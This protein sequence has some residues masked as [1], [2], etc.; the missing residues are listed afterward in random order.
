MKKP[1]QHN[2]HFIRVVSILVAT[3][4]CMIA[5]VMIGLFA[6]LIGIMLV[7]EHWLK[8]WDGRLFTLVALGCGGAGAIIGA[9]VKTITLRKVTQAHVNKTLEVMAVH[10]KEVEI[11]RGRQYRE[12]KQA[13][14]KYRCSHCGYKFDDDNDELYSC[15]HCHVSFIRHRG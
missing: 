5:G 7:P 14:L 10:E 3:W 8:A 6:Q 13:N 4:W 12:Y 11:E 15:P 2:V 9:V 1:L